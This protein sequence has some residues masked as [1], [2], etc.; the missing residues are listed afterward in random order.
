[1]WEVRAFTGRDAQGRPTQVSRTVR[2]AKRDANR[3]A[4]ELTVRRSS[5]A[6]KVALEHG[7][8]RRRVLV[9]AR[10]SGDSSRV[11][12]EGAQ[13]ARVALPW[14]RIRRD[15]A[16]ARFTAAGS[17]SPTLAASSSR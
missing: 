17:G 1:V 14:R 2:G 10:K 5:G 4:A 3:V 8:H 11:E 7:D 15:S 16:S 13:E 9:L 12:D 6:A